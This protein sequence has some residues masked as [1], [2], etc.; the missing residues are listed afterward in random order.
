MQH[1]FRQPVKQIRA[2]TFFGNLLFKIPV[3]RGDDAQLHLVLRLPAHPPG[4]PGFQKTQQLG[5]HADF[6]FPDFVQKQS[7]AAGLLH[8]ARP[9]FER[10]S[11]RPFLH[12]KQFRFE[13]IFGDGRAVQGHER[14]PATDLMQGAGHALL[15][16]AG[17]ALNQHAYIGRAQPVNRLP[18][19]LRGGRTADEHIPGAQRAAAVEFQPELLVGDRFLNHPLPAL[20]TVLQRQHIMRAVAQTFHHFGR[21][22]L[23]HPHEEETT[24]LR[25]PHPK[26]GPFGHVQRG[27]G[28][29]IN[30]ILGAMRDVADLGKGKRMAGKTQLLETFQGNAFKTVQ[31]KYGR[32]AIAMQVC[33][34]AGYL[35]QGFLEKW[36]NSHKVLINSLLKMNKTLAWGLL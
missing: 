35:Q 16:H 2:E 1:G 23:A 15:A 36:V 9:R 26:A 24:R 32:H 4:P 29:Q 28:N 30:H 19:A 3:G 10:A 12:A 5:L 31:M 25:Q 6:H 34:K 8:H 18:Q 14:P 13:Q 27:S 17:L 11:E 21:A 22:R 20:I 33:C 7:A